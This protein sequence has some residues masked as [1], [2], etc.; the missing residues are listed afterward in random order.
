VK[1]PRYRELGFKVLEILVTQADCGNLLRLKLQEMCKAPKSSMDDVLKD[2]AKRRLIL[3]KSWYINRQRIEVTEE[4][5]KEYEE[6][7]A[8]RLRFPIPYSVTTYLRH[9]APQVKKLFSVQQLF[10]ERGL[11]HS[12]NN[13]CVFGYPGSGK[14]LVTEMAMASEL[15]NRGRSLYCTP[16]KALDWQKYNDFNDW[17]GSGLGKKVVIT[18]GDNPVKMSDLLE[19]EIIIATYER[20]LGAIRNNEEWLNGITLVC[21]DEIT[22][23]DDEERGGDLDIMLTYLGLR[24]SPPRVITLSSLVGNPLQISEWLGAEPIIE[25]RPLP[26]IEIKEYLV[27]KRGDELSY[28]NRNGKKSTEKLKGNVVE[29]ILCRNLEKEET[30]LIFVGARHETEILARRLRSCHQYNPQL[31]ERAKA[32]FDDEIW[33]KTQLTKALCDLIGYGIAFHHAGVQRKARKFVESLLKENVLKT[34]VATTT[35]SHGIDYS[36]DNVIIDLPAILKIHELHGYEYINLKGRTGRFE[37][38]KSASVYILADEKLSKTAFDKYFLSSPEAIFPSRTFDKE[39]IA[40]IVMT[41]AERVGICLDAI[42]KEL[43]KTLCASHTKPRKSLVKNIM[44]ELVA[45]GFLK[46]DKDR[47]IIT[48]LGR[49]VNKANLSLYEAK[50]VLDLPVNISTV[51][52]LK[53]ASNIDI[54]RR[55]RRMRRSLLLFPPVREDELLQDW[56]NESSLDFIKAKHG[57]SYD[58]QDVIELGEYTSRSLQKISLLVSDSRLKKRLDTLQKMVRFGI[59]RDL[60]ESGLMEVPSL[61]RDK[62]RNLARS[63]FNSGVDNAD[64]LAKQCPRVLAEKI[65]IRIE[66]AE[67]LISDAVRQLH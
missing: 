13:V 15:D 22:L 32:F 7:K 49:T 19:G 39:A 12:R 5:R 10:V 24:D 8:E 60:A 61:S 50:V 47:F 56:M 59:K 33:E 54:A 67:S 31:A 48:E 2:L 23:L 34:I 21:A 46:Q 58:D 11:L 36:I 40:T 41:R 16:Y 25:N 51:E 28:L 6:A 20:V 9:R 43:S 53:V 17:F 57:S 45:F 38:S 3:K 44:E 42:M 64:K 26:G 65:G 1:R 35:L 30:T 66:L 27:F 63:L 37:K 14:T 29:H 52:L 18:D 62:K 4:G 55:M